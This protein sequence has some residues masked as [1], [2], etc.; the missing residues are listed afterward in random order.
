MKYVVQNRIIFMNFFNFMSF[1]PFS[2][3]NLYY[4][5]LKENLIFGKIMY[6]VPGEHYVHFRPLFTR[7]HFYN[8]LKNVRKFLEKTLYMLNKI[9][10]V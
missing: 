9:M 2:K 5:K 6:H 8:S 7:K 4:E 1:P 3:L 10:K